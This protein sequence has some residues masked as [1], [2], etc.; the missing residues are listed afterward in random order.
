[1][2]LG[3]EQ[4]I[5]HGFHPSHPLPPPALLAGIQQGLQALVGGGAPPGF[6]II[7]DGWQQTDVDLQYRKAGEPCDAFV[8]HFINVGGWWP[9][10]FAPSAGFRWVAAGPDG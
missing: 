4:G 7:D 8:L 2:S 5:R 6:L 9:A 3:V 10:D 1:M